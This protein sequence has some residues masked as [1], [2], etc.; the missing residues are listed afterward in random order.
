[1]EYSTAAYARFYAKCGWRSFPVW[2]KEKRPMYAGWNRDAT[3]DP[4]QIERYFRSSPNI[5]VVCGEAFDAWDIE[6]EHVERFAA[7]MEFNQYALPECP[8]ATTGR[9]GLHILTAPT[10]TDHT[11][12]LYLAGDHIGEL[13]SRGGFILVAPSTTE[14]QYQWLWRS[15]Q[16]AVQPAPDWLLGLLERPATVTRH[17]KTRLASPD[18]V[19]AVL[20]R[21][22]GSVQYAGEGSRNNYLYWAMRRAIE[23]GV[24]EKHAKRVLEV[25]AVES[26]L[27]R[28]E[29]MQ[30]IESALEAE[31]VAV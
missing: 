25:A 4:D 26:G 2:A 20:G 16:F 23:E 9:G 27:P 5:G 28:H 22:A 21:L 3:T 30:T 13:K 14:R 17:L 19:V 6:V 7:W 15:W 11:R 12:K 24:P 31:S 29:A 1:M 10:G 8:V 18:D